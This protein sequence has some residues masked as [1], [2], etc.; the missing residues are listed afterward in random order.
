MIQRL[1]PLTIILLPEKDIGDNVLGIA[2]DARTNSVFHYGG[3]QTV[4][5]M[6]LIGI[7]MP[8][9]IT[10]ATRIRLQIQ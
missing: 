1:I 5:E 2:G 4:M 6:Q 9:D 10:D 8:K 7:K 3:V